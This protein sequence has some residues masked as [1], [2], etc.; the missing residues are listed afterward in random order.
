MFRRRAFRPIVSTVA[1]CHVHHALARTRPLRFLL[2]KYK[3]VSERHAVAACR[4]L[5]SL[6]SIRRKANA[7]V[8]DQRS[9]LLFRLPAGYTAAVGDPRRAATHRHQVRLRCRPVRF[10][11]G[12]RQRRRGTLLSGQS[13]R[14]GGREPSPPSKD[15]I[16][17]N[18]HPVQQAWIEYQVPQCGY[19]QSGQIMQA[20][21]LLAHNANPSDQEIVDGMN[22]NLCRCATYSRI[23]G[24]VKRAAQTREGG[25]SHD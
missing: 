24:A 23:V 16:P 3:L 9:E 5:L 14:R 1:W 21:A 8:D 10:L 13:E 18:A 15:C 7:A 22:G 25:L 17:A 6:I 19:C 2:P 4:F 12:A 11:H 20:A